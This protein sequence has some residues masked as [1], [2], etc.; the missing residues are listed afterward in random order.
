MADQKITDLDVVTTLAD[1]DL[2]EVVVDVGG[3]PLNKKIAA[4]DVAS[5]LGSGAGYA[6]VTTGGTGSLD[7]VQGTKTTD[8]PFI[9]ATV[10]WNDSGVTFNA[11]D[12][13]AT[14]T[15]SASGSRLLRLRKSAS[16]MFE[17]TK[18]GTVSMPESG[19]F[20]QVAQNG[21]YRFAS[22]GRLSAGDWGLKPQDS[23]GNASTLEFGNRTPSTLGTTEDNYDWGTSAY[24][25]RLT[26]NAANT[27][28]TGG[29]GTP[30]DGSVFLIV[31]I[32]AAGTLTLVHQSA[33]SSAANRFLCSTGADIVLSPNQAADLIY[34]G[35]TQRYRVF[36]RS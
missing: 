2:F 21:S 13:N 35:T 32:A 15:A 36:K 20:V 3:T 27:S 28:M 22:A 17:V 7:F 6:G 12:L 10:T 11:I 29:R 30:P 25:L 23:G 31:N 5:E 18:A 14:D 24:F 9:D 4:S 8:E 1:T 26:A 34:D 33:S 16:T 19:S